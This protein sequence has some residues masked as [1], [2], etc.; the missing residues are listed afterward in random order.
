[1]IS[2]KQIKL[3]TSKAIAKKIRKISYL[4]ILSHIKLLTKLNET[5]FIAFEISQ[6]FTYK[7]TN[8]QININIL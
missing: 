8:K 3:L 4:N 2:P 6:Q 1:M 5:F 7:K